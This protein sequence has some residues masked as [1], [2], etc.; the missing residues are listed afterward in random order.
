VTHPEGFFRRWH[1]AFEAAEKKLGRCEGRFRIAH[2][3]V[4]LRA[5][6][7][8]LASR[9]SP[10]LK[11]LS[12]EKDAEDPLTICLWDLATATPPREH[13]PWSPT[14]AE[15]PAGPT[16]DGARYHLSRQGIQGLYE[17]H[18]GTLSLLDRSRKLALYAVPDSSAIPYYERAAPLRAILSWWMPDHGRY[19]I[20]AGA[21]GLKGRGVLVGGRGGTGKSTVTLAC[22]AAGYQYAGDDYVLIQERDPIAYSLYNTAKIDLD[23]AAGKFPAL[24]PHVS[25]HHPSDRKGSI[26]FGEHAPTQVVDRLSV[27]AVVLPARGTRPKIEKVSPSEAVKGIVPSTLL[28]LAG[29]G[30]REFQVI[31]R[32]ISDLPCFRLET[33]PEISDIPKLVD[34]VLRRCA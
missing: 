16:E 8:E 34:E 7:K 11:H 15:S 29:S 17:E 19:F 6:G 14:R 28:Q 18:S 4:V 13:I 9:I 22:L 12:W 33:G 5:A 24:L 27:D 32:W 2:K 10:A 21:V 1:A 3:A 20:H 30:P 25:E 23:H 31:A 26:Y